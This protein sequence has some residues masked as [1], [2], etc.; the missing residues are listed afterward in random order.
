MEQEVFVVARVANKI[1]TRNKNILLEVGDSMKKEI[2]FINHKRK[3]LLKKAK[4]LLVND[5]IKIIG[6]VNFGL[7]IAKNIYIN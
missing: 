4:E 2:V 1:T 6:V 3:G 7:I 5:V